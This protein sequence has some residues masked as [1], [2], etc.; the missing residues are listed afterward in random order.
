MIEFA[1]LGPQDF[2]LEI[3]P[4]KGALT[5]F[6]LTSQ[7]QLLAIEK[8]AD[9]VEYLAKRFP[10]KAHLKLLHQDILTFEL[11]SLQTPHKWKVISNLP[12]QLT[13]PLLGKFLPENNLIEACYFILQKELADRLVAKPHSKLFSHLSLFTQFYSEVSPLLE[14]PKTCFSPIPQVDCRLLSFKLK[15]PPLINASTFFKLT[16]EAFNQKRK[17]L[18][19]TL[20]Y[21][22][23]VIEQKLDE[24]KLSPLSRPEDLSVQNWVDLALSLDF[25]K[26]SPKK[27][28]Q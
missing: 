20:P 21:E 10:Q 16:R 17:M 26:F 24:L 28:E 5:E 12:F 25:E 14:I 11:S 1:R 6:I 13:S 4:G 2:V 9:L 22:G 19:K 18:R 3:G 7:C 8:D 23:I 27:N 15:K